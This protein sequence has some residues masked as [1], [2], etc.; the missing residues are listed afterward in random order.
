MLQ[1]R[2]PPE[3][4]GYNQVIED[5]PELVLV[6]I[7][8]VLRSLSST[9]VSPISLTGRVINATI[10]EEELWQLIDK[11][12]IIKVGSFIRLRNTNNSKLSSGIQCKNSSVIEHLY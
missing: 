4:V 8:K 5:P 10:W 12:G 1:T 6:E 3:I 7:D 9:I 2:L 11:D